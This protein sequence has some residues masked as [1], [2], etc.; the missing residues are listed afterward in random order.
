MRNRMFMHTARDD[1]LLGTIRFVS[2]QADTQIYG[3]ILPKAMTNQALLDS[4][5]YKTY[6][7]IASRAKH[8]KSRK[9]QKKSESAISSEESP[10]KKK[11]TKAKKDAATK[12]KPSKKKKLVKADI[13]KVLNVLS[14]VA[15]SEAAQVLNEQHRKITDTDKGTGIKPGVPDVPI[16]EFESKQESWSDSKEEDD[17]I[18][19]DSNDDG[20]D[21]NDDSDDDNKNND[22]DKIDSERTDSDRD[23]NPELTQS[24]GEQEEEED[25]SKRVHNPPEF[26]ST[27]DKEKMDEEEEVDAEE[28][29][30]DLNVN[31][32]T[33]DAKM[34]DVDQ[35]GAEQPNVSQDLGF[36]QEE[37]DAHVT[38]TAVHD[39]QKTVGPMQSSP[40]SSDFTSKL[41]NFDNT[42][43]RLDETSSQTSSLFTVPITAFPEITSATTVPP[44]PCSFNPF[45]R[46]TT[47]TPTPTTS[48]AT[49]SFLALPDFSSV[50]K[51]NDHVTNLEKTLSEMKQVDHYAQALSS[52]PAI[53]DGYIGNQLQET[54]QKS[55]QSHNAAYREE[56]QVEKQEYKDHID[57]SVRTIIREE[58]KTQL[59]QI[60]PKAVL[61][62][63]TP[64]IEKTVT[65]SLEAVVLA[66]SSSQP[67]STYEAVASLSEFK[68]T[69]ILMDKIKE[70]KY[71]Q[72]VGYKKELYDALVKSYNTDK[73]LFDS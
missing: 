52:I 57:T 31:L 34:T 18:V 73:D 41:L 45:P 56:A 33:K 4:I 54:I 72:V 55:I 5:A 38:L 11:P 59:P 9:S 60:L 48:E 19:N 22:D 8:P 36:Q 24:N 61:D 68:L 13:G 44:P 14:E 1:N 29:Y 23:E 39:T 51:F 6:Y 71:Y 35:G 40:V 70:G 10:S 47:P 50:F 28:L 21:D 16:Y 53:V 15:L 64:M 26:V 20:D 30:R 62:F 7:A 17:D 37:K 65:D 32:R 67:K 69:K 46:Q 27:H 2:R 58:V 3:T 49:T 42:P 63:A 66:K 25:D 43:P 12:T